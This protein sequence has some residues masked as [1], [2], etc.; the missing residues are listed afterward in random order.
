[1]ADNKKGLGLPETKGTFQ[2]RGIVTGTERDSFYKE[3]MTQKTNKPFRS[4]NYGVQINKDS[5]VYERLNGMERDKVYF[6]KTEKDEA[7]KNKTE[8]K[9]IDWKDRFKF[10]EDGFR[11]IGVRLGVSKV[12]DD[13][14][15]D[16]NDKKTLVEYDACKEIS[17]NL[18]DGVSVFTRGNIEY[19]Q[20]Q[21]RHSINFVP[22]QISLCRPID[23]EDPEYKSMADF[24]QEFVF[25]G[26]TPNEDKTEFAVEA[27]IVTYNTVEDAEFYITDHKLATLFKKNLK[28]YSKIKAWGKIVVEQFVEE[29]EETDGWGEKNEMEKVTAPT[30]RKLVITGA[31]PSTIDREVYSQEALDAAIEKVKASKQ[32]KKDYD[33][34]DWG[35]VDESPIMTDEDELW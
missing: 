9:A 4:V 2:I 34:D 32:A 15:N 16:V 24:T 28:P 19:S 7:G 35:S 27:K 22:N 23:F 13:K 29:V 18:V 1:M 3:T 33:G 31:D 11:L 10:D 17:E 5:T 25:M 30:Q 21:D 12:K 8:V 26:I 20:Y 14:G 6:S